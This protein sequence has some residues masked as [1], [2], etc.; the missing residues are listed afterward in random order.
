MSDDE[1]RPRGWDDPDAITYMLKRQIGEMRERNAELAADGENPDDNGE[2][3][4]NALEARL[5]QK[6]VDEPDDESEAEDE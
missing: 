4:E 2:M 5:F 1:N 6:I 3:L